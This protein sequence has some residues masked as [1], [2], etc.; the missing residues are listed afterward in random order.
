M[1]PFNLILAIGFTFASPTIQSRPL[2]SL[3]DATSGYISLTSERQL[4]LAWLNQLRGHVKTISD[5]EIETFLNSVIYKLVPNTNLEE[6]N[7]IS[8]IVDSSEL[9]AFAVPGGILGINAGLFIHARNEQEFASVLAHEL[10]HLSQRHYARNL[11]KQAT[12]RPLALAAFLASIVIAATAHSDAGMAA[13]AST[14]AY[15][16]Q[17]QLSFSRQ[18]EQ[19]ADRIGINTLYKSGFDPNAMPEMFEEMYRE[20][21]INGGTPPEY[22]L[23]HPVTESRIAES[24]SRAHQFH[25]VV[26][27]ISVTY[28]FMR[29]KML[30]HFANNTQTSINYFKD[31]LKAKPKP[32]DR[33]IYNY[34]LALAYNKNGN[35]N[36]ALKTINEIGNDYLNNISVVIARSIALIGLGKTKQAASE[37]NDQISLN[38]DNYALNMQYAEALFAEKK[39]H[40]AKNILRVQ[41]EAHPLEPHIWNRLSDVAGLDND[42]ILVHRA[43][44]EYDYLTGH[45]KKAIQQLS[46]ALKR[47]Q[48]NDIQTQIIQQRLSEL[49]KL[50]DNPS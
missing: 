43:K 10:A 22:L 25:H 14:Q 23:T 32:I 5:P 45:T 29:A 12:D 38:P 36:K 20:S 21:K 30:I 33:L 39:Y 42:I 49:F 48:G 26:T 24:T 47:A 35:F 7:I 17:N 46:I 2:P 8:V 16:I 41:A 34:G 13:L 4:G 19:E 3:G 28:H 44:A 18:N 27:H 37:L 40:Q 31:L 6:R 15:S 1:L 9:N 50:K 11:E